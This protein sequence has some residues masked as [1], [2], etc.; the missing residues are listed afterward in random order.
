MSCIEGVPL[1]RTPPLPTPPVSC[2]VVA[3]A[4]P[5]CRP[6]TAVYTVSLHRAAVHVSVRPRR[7]LPRTALPCAGDIGAAGHACRAAACTLASGQAGPGRGLCML[8][9]PRP[10]QARL[11]HAHSAQAGCTDIVLLDR[12]RIRPSGI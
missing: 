2:G 12:G 10:S 11:G 5:P 6:R 3:F 1:V 9:R 8:R 7:S 4:A